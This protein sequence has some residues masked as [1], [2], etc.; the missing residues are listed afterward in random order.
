MQPTTWPLHGDVRGLAGNQPIAILGQVPRRVQQRHLALI[1]QLAISNASSTSL[2]STTTSMV[3][4]VSELDDA[5]A[6]FLPGPTAAVV[7]L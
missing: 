7:M 6:A 4:I 1:D 2:C 5:L 3:A